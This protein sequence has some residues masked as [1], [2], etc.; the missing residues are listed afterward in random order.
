L[1]VVG[2]LCQLLEHQ[3][4]AVLD[5]IQILLLMVQAAADIQPFLSHQYLKPIQK[6]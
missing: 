3:A 2:D 6:L 4:E 5:I 1:W